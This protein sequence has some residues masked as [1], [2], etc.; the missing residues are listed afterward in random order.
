MPSDDDGDDTDGDDDDDDDDD[1]D[2][3]GGDDVILSVVSMTLV[4]TLGLTHKGPQPRTW[5]W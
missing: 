5:R 1:D 2:G 4:M 3:D